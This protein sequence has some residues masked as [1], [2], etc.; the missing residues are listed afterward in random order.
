[1]RGR[2]RVVAMRG[3][4]AFAILLASRRAT[5]G[6]QVTSG[7]QSPAT[8]SSAARVQ[9]RSPV[10]R[11]TTR[12]VHINVIVNDKHG[13]PVPGLT[14]EN[15]ELLVDKQPQPIQ[16]FSVDTNFP[17]SEDEDPLPPNTYSNRNAQRSL[18]S[19]ATVILLDELNTEAADKSFARAQVAKFLSRVQPNERVALYWLGS[20]L[21]VLHEFSGNSATLRAAL[22]AL[23]PED[24]RLLANAQPE[25]PSLNNPNSST[26]AGSSSSREAFRRTFAQRSANEASVDRVRATVAALIAIAN[27]VG[28][29]PGRK[30]LVWI[31]SAFPFSLGYDRFDLDWAN[32]TGVNFASSVEAAARSLSNAD[33]AMYPVDARGL[34]GDVMTARE[35]E[36]SEPGSEVFGE[37]PPEQVNTM[38][39]LAERTGGLAFYNS[40]NL[41]GAIRRAI[42]DSRLTYTLGY[43]PENLKWDGSFHPIHVKV[44]VPGAAVRSRS[45]FFALSDPPKVAPTERSEVLQTAS[46]ALDSTAIRLLLDVR[47]VNV[48]ERTLA[49]R[50]HLDLHEIQMEQK[51]LQWTGRLQ[52]VF[53]LFDDHGQLISKSDRT[54]RLL[55]EPAVYQRILR[56]GLSDTRQLSVAPAASQLCVVVRDASN[57]KIG[58]IL[59]PLA[60]YF[61]PMPPQPN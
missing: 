33:I 4:L 60:K 19:N 35:S 25:D 12:L 34:I 54:F 30:N 18:P 10:L 14:K 36:I 51:G 42:D 6:A 38:K 20:N 44:S 46:S 43:Y 49:V 3:A 50:L 7:E 31:S 29:L 61:S 37:P 55:F 15:F 53:F 13:N 59:I 52:S 39:I 2:F 1:M 16:F 48:A 22:A 41:S 8:E 23:H 47:T 27:H 58:S 28:S 21:R 56:N 5:A 26:P 57:G 17:A 32:D 11:A 40:N 9:E 24:S 45:G